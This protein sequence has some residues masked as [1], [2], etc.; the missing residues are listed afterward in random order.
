MIV[1]AEV[2]RKWPGSDSRCPLFA[3]SVPLQGHTAQCATPRAHL[4]H[5]RTLLGSK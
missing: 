1:E 3:T 2:T 5:T 4:V